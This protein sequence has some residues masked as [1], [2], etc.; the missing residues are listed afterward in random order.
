M[1]RRVGWEEQGGA[2]DFAAPS[3]LPPSRLHRPGTEEAVDQDSPQKD[4]ARDTK[5][6]T[7][8]RK[9]T[10]K[11]SSVEASGGALTKPQMTVEALGFRFGTFTNTANDCDTSEIEVSL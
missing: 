4:A 1:N 9:A 5:S 7:K 3:C 10:D 6:K 8:K 2:Q 11:S